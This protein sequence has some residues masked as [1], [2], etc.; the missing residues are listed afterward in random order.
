MRSASLT[1]PT[2]RLNL[3]RIGFDSGKAGRTVGTLDFQGPTDHAAAGSSGATRR[4][5][6]QQALTGLT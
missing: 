1:H 6:P 4:N 2:A 5:S 3:V